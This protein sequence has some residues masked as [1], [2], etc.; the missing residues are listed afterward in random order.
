[1][2]GNLYLALGM[3]VQIVKNYMVHPDGI[4]NGT[5]GIVWGYDFDDGANQKFLQ[6]TITLPNGETTSFS[7]PVSAD[8]KRV[9]RPRHILVQIPGTRFAFFENLPPDVYPLPLYKKDSIIVRQT[10]GHETYEV[11]V[12]VSQ[13]GLVRSYGRIPRRHFLQNYCGWFAV[14][15]LC[16][17]AALHNF[18]TGKVN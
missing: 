3:P 10:V 6:W 15:C 17:P 1:M 4:A 9:V 11:R 18:V 13:F 5:P 7:V 14:W 8:R 12:K 2:Q 16:L